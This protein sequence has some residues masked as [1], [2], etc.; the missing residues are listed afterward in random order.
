MWPACRPYSFQHFNS[1]PHEEADYTICVRRYFSCYFNSQP[2]E[3]AD[4]RMF[5]LLYMHQ[6]FNS[7]PHEEADIIQTVYSLIC[8]ISTHS[9]TKRLTTTISAVLYKAGI[10]THSLTKRL[11]TS[12][13]SK[14][15]KLAF[16][17][18]ASRRG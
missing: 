12:E 1:Q 15:R 5:H 7:Q 16:Q 18:T 2:H 3:E 9:L 4:I 13:A 10:S 17:L 14:P 6:H 11:T 8:S